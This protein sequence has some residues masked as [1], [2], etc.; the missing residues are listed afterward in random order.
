MDSI[1]IMAHKDALLAG[2][3]DRCSFAV[4]VFFLAHVII[5]PILMLATTDDF[6]KNKRSLIKP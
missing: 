2:P 1:P 4:N 3:F 6:I 5:Q